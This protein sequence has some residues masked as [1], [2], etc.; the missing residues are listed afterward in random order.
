MAGVIIFGLTGETGL[1]QADL[2]AGTVLPLDSPPNG[3]LATAASFRKVGAGFYKGVDF[4][5]HVT[6]AANAAEG[7]HEVAH[8]LHEAASGLHEE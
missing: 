2:E 1:W 4:A 6:T 8:G 3:D 7:L 5:V